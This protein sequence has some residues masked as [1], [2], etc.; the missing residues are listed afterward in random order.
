M[1]YEELFE[2]LFD[3]EFT[4]RYEKDKERAVDVIIPLLNSNH[5]F[6]K[7]LINFYKRIPI[8][9][10]LIGDGGSTDDCLEIL[11]KFPRVVVFD[12]SD[13]KSQG[14]SIK[15]LIEACETES[16]I[17]LHADVFL[18]ENWFDVM[19]EH[20]EES[21]WFECGR[22]MI[23][24]VLWDSKQ[25]EKERAYSGSQFGNTK[26]MQEAIAIVEDD[27]LQR[28]EDIIIAELVGMEGYK[29]FLDTYHYHQM[30]AKKGEKEPD[31][32]IIPQFKRERD[33]KWEKRIYDM[34]WKGIVK[35][36]KPKKDYLI[37]SVLGAIKVLRKIDTFNDEEAKAWVNKNDE[38]W[39]KHIW[40]K[41]KLFS[42]LKG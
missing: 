21:P 30:Q 35:Y 1:S 17:Y 39:I 14:Y 16:M 15:M 34:Q 33:V 27:F 3:I 31:L 41:R 36:C 9:R 6:E 4:D 26:K 32:K 24:L 12:Q 8:N 7:S 37:E 28:N 29:K 2:I 20:R 5:Y 18:P 13:F 25:I 10:L 23:S 38:E 11:K 42:F 22:K 40:P 19:W